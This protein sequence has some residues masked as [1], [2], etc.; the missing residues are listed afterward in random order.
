MRVTCR[1]RFPNRNNVSTKTTYDY[2]ITGAGCSGISLLVRLIQSGKFQNKRILLIEKEQ[3]AS[4]DR[5][6]CFWEQTPGL[7][8]PIVYKSWNRLRFF[9]DDFS[10]QLDI[11][12][13]RYK[14]IRGIDFYAHGLKVI[15]EANNVEIINGHVESIRNGEH[16]AIVRL[17]GQEYEASWVF[18]SILFTQPDLSKYYSLQQHFK[19]WVIKTPRPVFKKDEATLMDFR[20]SQQHGTTFV[21]VLP[22]DETTALVEYTLFTRDL[23]SANEYD[24]ALRDYLTDFLDLSEYQ[25]IEEEFG[26]IPMTNYPFTPQDGR[27]IHLG[28]AGGH[29][30]ASS[31]YTF[32]FIQ[33]N[34]ALLTES[35]IQTG[36]PLITKPWAA[37]RF[38]FYDSVLLHILDQKKLEGRAVFT[39]LFKKGDAQTVLKFLDNET[40]FWDDLHIMYRLPK[41]I[42]ATAAWHELRS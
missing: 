13:Y 34:T 1:F 35:L 12:P 14:M 10:S 15:R 33:K 4:N 28:T 36:E 24:L 18:N 19:G 16:K 5:T 22:Y 17:N 6:W 38:S 3:K 21:Y 42:F 39:D 26:V 7:F 41:R 20:V 27:I 11:E 8:E 29:T 30:K 9:G 40:T 23:L 2:I 31:G 32:Q 37:K 25:I